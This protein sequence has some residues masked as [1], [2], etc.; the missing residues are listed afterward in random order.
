MN[1]PEW[2]RTWWYPVVLAVASLAVAIAERVRPRR[3]EQ[4]L[5][6]PGLA[7][8][9]LHLVFNGHFLGVGLAWFGQRYVFPMTD[10][11]LNTWG[12][13]RAVAAQWPAWLAVPVALLAVDLMQWGVHLLLHRVGFLWEIHKVHHSVVDGEMDFWVAFRF[14]WLEVVVYR[15][16]LYLPMAFLGFGVLP[17]TVHAVVGTVVGHLNH[18]NLDLGHGAWRYVLNNPRMHMHHH[19]ASGPAVNFGII[20]SAWDFL[21]G[22]AHNPVEPPE[23]L[24]FDGVQAVPRGFVGRLVWPL[25]SLAPAAGTR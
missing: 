5:I 14:H 13:D 3:K 21:A 8:D 7:T 6:R 9:V 11:W 22:T 18:S 2:L 20:F 25:Q 10:V 19:R 16:L 4:H 12:V 17:M 15:S 24:G 1:A 23:H